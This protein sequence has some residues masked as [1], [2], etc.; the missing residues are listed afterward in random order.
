MFQTHKT[1]IEI[2]GK[3]YMVLKVIKEHHK[4]IIDTWKEHLGAEKCFRQG[5][6]LF[7]VTEVP[8]AEVIE[9]KNDKTDE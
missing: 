7:F 6:S 1:F 2:E 8:E 5:D 3:L 9:E 4:P